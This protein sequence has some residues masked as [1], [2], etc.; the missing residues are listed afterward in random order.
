MANPETGAGDF[1]AAFID[2]YFAECDEH[3]TTIRR[4]L[5][6]A[7]SA[8]GGELPAHTI[9][10]LFRAFHS[11][12]GLSG[13]VEL[14]DAELLAHQLESYLRLLRAREAVLTTAGLDALISGTSLLEQVIGA[15]RAGRPVPATTE[16]AVQLEALAATS[17][18]PGEA[19]GPDA[20]DSTDVWRVVFSPSPALAARGVTVDRVR[21]W[22]AG[23][24]RIVDASPRIGDAGEIR[25]EFSL[26]DV[27]DAAAFGGWTEGGL[28]VAAVPRS[29][30][31]SPAAE[32]APD[33]P[34]AVQTTLTSSHFVRVDLG[35][36][37]ELMRIIGDVV[38]TR[39]RLAESLSRLERR[40][41]PVEWRAVQEDSQAMERQLRDLREGVMRV[42]LVRVG[43][44]F[45]RMPF[46][47]RDLARESGRQV[48]LQISGQE[49]E[50]DKYL[51]ERM[52][53][54]VLHLVRN[55]V[56]HGIEPADERRAAGKSEAGR[57]SLSAAS[58]GDLVALE[59]ADDG[60]G[61]DIEAVKR[62]ARAIGIP[63]GDHPLEGRELLGI[64]CAPGF[65]TR[66]TADRAAGRGVGMAVVQSAVRELGGTLTLDTAPG[67]GTRFLIELPLTLAITDAIIAA[68][69]GQMF[70]VPQSSVREVMDVS[71]EAIRVLENHEIM[72]YRGG[73]L[74]LLRLS[75]VFGLVPRPGRTIHVFVIGV[76]AAAVGIA[77]DRIHTQREIVVRPMNDP[78]IK[79]EGITG[80][81][82][83][84]D[85]RV[86]LILDLARAARLAARRLR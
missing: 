45:D 8:V 82:D 12:K 21:A 37:D 9:E 7:P 62:R 11:I 68:A 26:E 67:Q 48:E 33:A 84:G 66:D 46:V 27:G 19:P 10:E 79:A 13:M 85:G 41:P 86:V 78:L 23:I 24:G 75:S 83:L 44:I 56:S 80:A 73:V 31:G 76:G 4:L 50:I 32:A 54:P 5:A 70:A 69:G 2:D 18:V 57:V 61:V 16:T 55:A 53:D 30:G 36:L 1:L 77:V 3:L 22:L 39:A 42:R 63:T 60:R 17:A 34:G 6:E 29:T 35:R 14:R 51:V 38:I 28:A 15:R 25:F 47:V 72:P 43:E 64:L 49:T 81:T 74:P 65:S 59:I 52:M 20:A 58:V 71:G 40:V